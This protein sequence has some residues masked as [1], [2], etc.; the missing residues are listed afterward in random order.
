M[1]ILQ[2]TPAYEPAF[3]LG[4][5]VRSAGQL[6]RGLARLG[7]EVTV[8]TTEAGLRGKAGLPL[9]EPVE[10]G[11]VLVWYFRHEFTWRQR[12]AF[13]RR[14]GAALR[15]GVHDF[16][17]VHITSMW[18]YPEI[19]ASREAR[20]QGVPYVIGTT[21]GFIDLSLAT[22]VWKKWFYLKLVED[23][24]LKHASAIRFT[25][26]LERER[27]EYLQRFPAPSFIV[28]NGFQGD[29]FA[30]L[31]ERGAA[32]QEFQVDEE[33]PKILYLGRLD[34]RKG[35]EVVVRA[36]ARVVRRLSKALLMLA[37]PDFGVEDSL[38]DEVNRLGLA[39]HVRFLGYVPPGRRNALLRTA[40]VLVLA[41]RP[42]E[43]FGNAAVEAM[44]AGVPVLLSDQVGICR[45][46]AADGAGLVAPLQ[47]EA[48]A[49]ALLEML[50]DPAKRARM[51]ER[52]ATAARRR[53]AIETVARQM[54]T[55]YEDILTGRRSPELDWS[56]YRGH[57]PNR[58]RNQYVWA[59]D[60]RSP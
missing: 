34:P 29:E 24:V 16:D 53:Y 18:W 52:A 40:D 33:T 48:I 43:N 2:V 56:D 37:G 14:L 30:A 10:V 7:H 45:E 44:F 35:L 46:V 21:G 58:Q 23:P 38:R 9:N 54:A 42:G 57:N 12:F 59:G 51:G 25:A 5:V 26:S 11:G 6:C 19:P 17:L 55:A 41:A 8:F 50:T 27:S 47:E 36:L 39:A 1:K 3:E 4:G 28:P 22:T 20:R 31:P 49:A 32:C 13:S 15:E 60:N